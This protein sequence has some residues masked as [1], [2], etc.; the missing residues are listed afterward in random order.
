MREVLRR[1][2]TGGRVFCDRK[3]DYGYHLDLYNGEKYSAKLLVFTNTKHG[4]F[5]FH[6]FKKE[7]MFLLEGTLNVWKEGSGVKVMGLS[8]GWLVTFEPNTA[9]E[10][11][12]PDGWAVVL[13]IA[14]HDDDSDTYRIKR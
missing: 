1:L 6:H 3:H 2:I 14:T 4:S 12:S 5:H 7:T 8:V 13:E 10:M 11:W 9:H